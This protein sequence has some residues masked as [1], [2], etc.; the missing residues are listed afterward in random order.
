MINPQSTITTRINIVKNERVPVYD[1][2]TRL[3]DLI[4][5]GESFR[6]GLTKRRPAEVTAA[7]TFLHTARD[8]TTTTRKSQVGSSAK[9]LPKI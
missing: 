4:P 2:K 8:G 6:W 7:S 5:T 1:I 3:F 9:L